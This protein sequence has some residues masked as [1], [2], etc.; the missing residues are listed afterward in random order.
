MYEIE[1]V[2]ESNRQS[3]IDLLKADAIRHVFA[4]YDVQY[5]PEHTI[6]YAAFEKG[7]L[8]GYILIYTA[9][10]FPSV[11]LE[12]TGDVA[13]ELMSYVPEGNFIMQA[14]PQLLPI[15]KDRFPSVK[16]YVEDWMRVK[17]GEANFFKSILVRKLRGPED[18]MKLKTL[19]ST[20]EGRP[21]ETIERCI[22]WMSRMPAYGVF[23]SGELVSC[24]GSFLQLPQVW[25]IGGVYT[26]PNQRNKGYAT[27]ATSA[28][29]EEALERAESAALFVRSDNR[30]AIRV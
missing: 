30:P 5:E 4:L 21:T 29:T 11:I 6:M 19:L 22:S 26:H 7:L 12:C 28:I 14:P 27:L 9:M 24:A 1:R 2:D 3:V 16:H 25:M 15:I 17:R 10:E 23:V 13:G 8:K 20:W 18:A